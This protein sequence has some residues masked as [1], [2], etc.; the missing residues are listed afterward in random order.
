MIQETEEVMATKCHEPLGIVKASFTTCEKIMQMPGIDCESD[1]STF[2]NSATIPKESF[3]KISCPCTCAEK[4][5]DRRRLSTTDL[6]YLDDRVRET[7]S[8]LEG[9]IVLSQ[10]NALTVEL[11]SG[12]VVMGQRS[13]FNR[14]DSYQAQEIV[15]VQV[16]TR[17]DG[18]I[19]SVNPEGKYLV[20]FND[21][22]KQYVP[23]SNI[24]SS[25]AFL[26]LWDSVSIVVNNELQSGYEIVEVDHSTNSYNLFRASDSTLTMSVSKSNVR[27]LSPFK[28]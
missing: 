2:F 25:T 16:C 3:V 9:K 21:N 23:F 6:V 12:A 22:S 20:Q 18:T 27:L 13:Q 14:L 11:D 17:H 24:K 4:I 1:L 10:N 7:S 26:R 5:V 28:L 8:G 19:Q 15:Q